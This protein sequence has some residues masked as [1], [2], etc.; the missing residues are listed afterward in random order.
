MDGRGSSPD[1]GVVLISSSPPHCA[2]RTEGGRGSESEGLPSPRGFVSARA[3]LTRLSGESGGKPLGAGRREEGIASEVTAKERILRVLNGAEEAGPKTKRTAR[4]LVKARTKYVEA[5]KLSSTQILDSDSSEPAQQTIVPEKK[6]SAT[7]IIDSDDIGSGAEPAGGRASPQFATGRLTRKAAGAALGE[8]KADLNERQEVRRRRM[9]DRAAKKAQKIGQSKHSLASVGEDCFDEKSGYFVF[10][11]QQA[12]NDAVVSVVT[13]VGKTDDDLKEDSA[14]DLST[15][16]TLQQTPV[17]NTI[18]RALDDHGKE[19]SVVDSV[20]RLSRDPKPILDDFDFYNNIFTQPQQRAESGEASAKRR[21]V[22]LA[23]TSERRKGSK[24]PSPSK[25]PSNKKATKEKTLKGKKPKEKKPKAPPKKAQTIT[26]LATAAYQQP[27]EPPVDATKQSTVSAFFSAGESLTRDEKVTKDTASAEK[28]TKKPRKSR[29][30]KVVAFDESGSRIHEPPKP[31]K[32]QTTKK[33]KSALM[34]LR[35]PLY[36]PAEACDQIKKQDFVFGTSSQLAVDESPTLLKETLQALKESET[37]PSRADHVVPNRWDHGSSAFPT[38]ITKKQNQGMA[39]KSSKTRVPSAPHGTILS[40][41]QADRELW[42][43]ASRDHGEGLLIDSGFGNIGVDE[44]D[45]QDAPLIPAF[46]DVRKSGVL[47]TSQ[48]VVSVDEQNALDAVD[49]RERVLKQHDRNEAQET[50]PALTESDDQTIVDLCYSSP[51]NVCI[52]ADL[53]DQDAR[54]FDDDLPVSTSKLPQHDS[55]SLLNTAENEDHWMSLPSDSSLSLPRHPGNI[56]TQLTSPARSSSPPR[57]FANLT[58]V[59]PPPATAMP[60]SPTRPVLQPLDANISLTGIKV[61][62]KPIPASAGRFSTSAAFLA[63]KPASPSERGRGRPRKV[64]KEHTVAVSTPVKPKRGR[65]KKDQTALSPTKPIPGPEESKSAVVQSDPDT[66][67]DID[68]V[69]EAEHK[70]I[71][72]RRCRKSAEKLS[73]S[74]PCSFR[75]SAPGASLQCS[76]KRASQGSGSF[77]DIDEISDSE[78]PATPSPP[79]RRARSSPPAVQPLTLSPLGPS[80]CTATEST[81][82][83]AGIFLMPLDADLKNISA[84]NL[85]YLQSHLFPS[86]TTAIKKGPP[87]NGIGELTWHE[88]MLIYDPIIVEDLADWLNEIVGLKVPCLRKKV[89]KKAKVGRKRKRR[90]GDQ[91]DD[92]EASAKKEETVQ[93]ELKPWM[94]QKW[95]EANS[96]C[97]FYKTGIGFN[98]GPRGRNH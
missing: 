49:G 81:S 55:V 71:R 70:A 17:G 57:P 35:Q 14:I 40:C 18:T 19:A 75:Q 73:S 88:K 27:K 10:D 64:E 46:E 43:V 76:L 83:T 77:H 25:S 97:C 94:V 79:R 45:E 8:W 68:E 74:P 22:E 30:R 16:I 36:A 41:G 78:P 48:A 62:E 63:R 37:S 31:S 20:D 26:A 39:A 4:P 93:E 92:Q 28:P 89:V 95:C 86:I 66:F 33:G 23:N 6:L 34:A 24:D 82:R 91:D 52:A 85:S 69:S 13:A 72:S 51:P 87:S 50:V 12:H 2:A 54:I 61:M 44:L 56:N 65:P 38:S 60:I 29:A 59:R 9:E 42:C 3:A 1:A 7:Q 84:E 96:I 5:R 58:I 47:H 32:R 80:R 11:A 53:P 90:E 98:W 67:L 21:K 15:G